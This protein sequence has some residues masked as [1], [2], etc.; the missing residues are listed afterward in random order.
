MW[1]ICTSHSPNSFALL[2]YIFWPFLHFFILQVQ[3]ASRRIATLCLFALCWAF[4][5]SMNMNY[6][7]CRAAAATTTYNNDVAHNKDSRN[8]RN[9]VAITETFFLPGFRVFCLL[10]GRWFT[11]QIRVTRYR[12]LLQ[13]VV[14]NVICCELFYCTVNTRYANSFNMFALKSHKFN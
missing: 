7:N 6:G 8:G 14:D 13:C 11:D 10:S 5:V 1:S 4:A 9:T 2:S 3:V 12:Q